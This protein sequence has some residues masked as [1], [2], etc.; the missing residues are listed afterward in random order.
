MS[1]FKIFALIALFT[2]ALGLAL[3]GEAVAGEKENL[4]II[5]RNLHQIW[6]QQDFGVA[7]EIVAEDYVRHLPGGGKV[8][9]REGYKE[10]V[11]ADMKH[12]WRFVMDVVAPGGDYVTVRYL[13]SG[14]DPET[15][16]KPLKITAIVIH[17]LKNGKMVED[18][19]DFD[20][21]GY[22][23]QLGYQLVPPSE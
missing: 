20:S 5:E 21:A 19:V 9:G 8:S 7:D 6:H 15:G 10:Y 12:N 2:F 18:W 3:V 23:K 13:G 11:K 14:A 4:I 16:K 1:R 22:F 17:R